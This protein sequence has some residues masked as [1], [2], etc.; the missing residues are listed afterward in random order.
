MEATM[1]AWDSASAAEACDLRQLI[2]CTP[3]AVM[4]PDVRTAAFVMTAFPCTLD[5]YFTSHRCVVP[6][7]I[8][9][10]I[11]VSLI[12][13][14]RALHSLV[15]VMHTDIA[16][17]NI[18][19]RDFESGDVVLIDLGAAE[20][21]WTRTSYLGYQ[22]LRYA[23]LAVLLEDGPR[24]HPVDDL[25][26][27]GYVLLELSTGGTL[28][29]TD[30]TSWDEM[31]PMMHDLASRRSWKMLRRYVTRVRSDSRQHLCLPAY[32]EFIAALGDLV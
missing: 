17:A 22:R 16:P 3:A 2:T 12:R 13:A 28:P 31:I 32:D 24:P 5:A 6:P 10:A 26:A 21:L 19:V 7:R 14:C 25:E 30:K 15:G 27:V 18:A 29:W 1:R 4:Y 8:V 11:G 20:G 9:L 23:P